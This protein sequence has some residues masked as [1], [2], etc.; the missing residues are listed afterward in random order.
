MCV[1]VCVCVCDHTKVFNHIKY[2]SILK[3]YIFFNFYFK[4]FSLVFFCLDIILVISCL[5]QSSLTRLKEKKNRFIKIPQPITN[6]FFFS[7]LIDFSPQIFVK[8]KL[9]SKLQIDAMA[10][11]PTISVDLI[12]DQF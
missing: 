6:Q 5:S 12:L 7:V 3:V 10:L 4:L 1:C 9:S 8:Y 2:N 11:F